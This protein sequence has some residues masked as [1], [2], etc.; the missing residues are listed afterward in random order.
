MTMK[1]IPRFARFAAATALA[2]PLVGCAPPRYQVKVNNRTDQP[3][4]AAV[5]EQAEGMDR[6]RVSRFIG[7]E[8]DYTLRVQSKHG[9]NVWLSV[10][11]AG[12]EGRPAELPL[13][14]GL[15]VVNVRRTEEGSRGGIQLQE[16]P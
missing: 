9:R 10:D 5:W 14:T 16:V 15:T 4:T 2:L 13:S 3:V 6:R 1:P 11:F 8:H 12:N 7:P